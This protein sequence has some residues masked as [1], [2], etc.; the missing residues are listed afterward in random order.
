MRFILILLFIGIF[1]IVGFTA[2]KTSPD[3]DTPVRYA[4]RFLNRLQDGEY[5]LAVSNFGGNVCRCPADLG[6]VSYLI[7]ESNEDPNL[8]FLMDRRF[9]CGAVTFKKMQSAVQE[10]KHNLTERPQDF[11]V[12]VPISFDPAI[13]A[14]YFLPLDMAYGL[15]MK[16]TD[17]NNFLG[18]PDHD[19]WKFMTLRLRPSLAKG[20]ITMPAEA[21]EQIDSY[22]RDKKKREAERAADNASKS[23]NL[24]NTADQT[25]SETAKNLVQQALAESADSNYLKVQDAG[26]VTAEDGRALDQESIA[27]RLP[28]LKSALLKLHM[29]RRDPTQPFTVFHFVVSDPVLLVPQT[30]GYHQ[31]ALKNF[32]PPMPGQ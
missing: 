18:D 9:T 28:R 21:K 26:T 4:K 32:K 17:L 31:L 13:Y 5:K 19:A 2:L 30:N 1:L 15:P 29:V 6:W 25:Q 23:G 20:T 14:P 3:E 27:K 8:A 10:E 12:D 24:I 7:Y 16:S 22:V 11:E